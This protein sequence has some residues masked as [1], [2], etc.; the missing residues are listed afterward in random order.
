MISEMQLQANR[1][2]ALKSTGP[3]TA[4]GKA[5]VAANALRHGL[6]SEMRVLP[7]LEDAQQWQD[8]LEQTLD[9]LSPEGHMECLLAEQIALLLWRLARA[10]RYEQEAAAAE[11]ENAERRLARSVPAAPGR[12]G[13]DAPTPL[14]AADARVVAAAE[15]VGLVARL[16][17]LSE[18]ELIP[19]ACKLIL[20]ARELVEVSFESRYCSSEL[21]VVAKKV[22]LANETWSA[23]ELREA[24]DVLAD[25][26]CFTLD[27]LYAKLT[28]WAESG[29]A[30]AQRQRDELH[31][32]LDQ[33]RRLSLLPEDKELAKIIRHEAH[34][35]R[36]LSRA[37]H[38]LQ[39]RQAAR[40]GRAVP[41]PLA[42][43]ITGGG[44]AQDA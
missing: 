37:M 15:T 36:M 29:L 28:A 7:G 30:R 42:V 35:E 25:S 2:N 16:R 34:V 31:R 27:E 44:P 38:E 39:R 14:E 10:A 6:V 1:A 5:R 43:D 8:H 4:E 17:D 18:D 3:R 21:G 40:Q 33:Y 23:G 32:T 24:L 41:L 13:E 22:Q 11:F 12:Q 26:S 9:D 20:T 19:D